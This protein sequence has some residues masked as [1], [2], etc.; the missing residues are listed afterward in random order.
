MS[1]LQLFSNN[2]ISLLQVSISASD[3]SITLQPGQG[4]LF[5]NPTSAGEF[6]LITLE[7][8]ANPTIREIVKIATRV[9]DTLIVA[10]GGRGWEQTAALNWAANDTLVDHRITAETI[11]QAFL[12]PQ[13]PAASTDIEIL[14]EGNSL[15]T[16]ASSL[17]FTGSGVTVSSAGNDITVSIPGAV[18][19][20]LE[21]ANEGTT[22]AAS[23][24]KFTFVGSGVTASAVGNEITINVPGASS[25]GGSGGYEYTT[26]SVIPTRSESIATVTY[27]DLRRANKFWVSMVD[28]ASGAAQ[29]FEILTVIQGLITTNTETATW[30]KTNRIG[31]DFNGQMDVL[32]NAPANQLILK[33]HNLEASA[34]VV[35]SVMRI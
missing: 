33:W 14:D 20:A 21:V 19:L 27:S 29:S 17:N 35:V 10:S 6:F 23:A 28:L 22:I 9:G 34:T 12:H 30:T 5:P 18:S 26:V 1:Q 31:Y 3:M 25:G 15:S 24:S 4:S 16:Q 8:I 13:T 32:L 2:A 7:D 11:R